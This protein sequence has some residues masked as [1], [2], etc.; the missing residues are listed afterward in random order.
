MKLLIFSDSHG[1]LLPMRDAIRR[2][3][4]D[5]VLHLG[6]H[7][8]DA[9]T[10][11]QEFYDLPIA[12]VRGNCDRDFPPCAETYERTLEGVRI[13]AAHGHRFGVKYDRLRFSLAA[14]ERGATLALYGH[15]HCPDCTQQEGLWLL[16]PGACGGRTPTY[17]VALLTNGTLHCAVKEVY[18]EEWS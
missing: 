7:A 16:N 15:T 4:P 11:S 5:A 1:E 17:G 14:Q 8:G 2:E 9:F 12:Y 3:R 6:D 13:F 10:L 18:S